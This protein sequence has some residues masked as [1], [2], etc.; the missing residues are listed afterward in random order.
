MSTLASGSSARHGA[1]RRA[2]VL[3]F[4]PE[5]FNLA[6]VT[7]TLEIARVARRSFECV[8]SSY[9]ARGQHHAFIEQAGF[10]IVRLKPALSDAHIELFWRKNRG[11]SIA[12]DYFDDSELAARVE[13]ERA[14]YRELGVRA[15]VT[16]FCLSTSLSARQANVPLVWINQTTWLS[17]Y[18][19]RF[20]T[21]PD[22]I[23]TSLSRRLPGRVRDRLAALASPFTFWTLNRGF[24]RVARRL[25]IDPFAGSSL[26]E[27]DQNLFAEPPD[28]SGLEL[29]ARLAGRHAFIGPL[30]GGLPLEVPAAIRELPRDRPI[31]YFAMGSS[32]VEDL[33]A[34]LIPAFRGQP[35]RVIAPVA[36]LLRRRRVEPPENVIVTDWIPAEKVNPM[37]DVSVVHGG[38]GTLLTACA[39]GTP[40]VAIP[41]GNPE[42][43][44]NVQCLV[45]KGIAVH[46]HKRRITPEDVLAAIDRALGDERARASAREF[47]KSVLALNGPENAARLLEE[48]YA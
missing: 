36:P 35:Y 43:E 33:I 17:E 7:R 18:F 14:L 11:E 2:P 16:G 39:A 47:Q 10:R 4:A 40:I 8:F 1:S 41:N 29:P 22:A 38:I 13:S 44:C 31:V 5:T 46:L 45:R 48:K 3:L 37:A 24:N 34:D 28:F 15:V 20:G 12:Q 30:F 26:L 32:G 9:D 42:Q 25:G 27:G 19:R 23:D 21:W 6:E